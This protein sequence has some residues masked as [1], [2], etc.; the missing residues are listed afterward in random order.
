[1][2][3]IVRIVRMVP[4]ASKNVQTIGT[5][6]WKRYPDDR[7]RPGS[8]QILHDRPDRTQF[9]PSDRGRLSRPGRF[10]SSGQRFHMI[11]P[12]VWTFRKKS[13][14]RFVDNWKHRLGLESA[15][16]PLC[17]W[18]P[19]TR[20]TFLSKTFAKSLNIQKQYEKNV[21]EKSNDAY[22]LST[23]VQSTINHRFRFSRFDVFYGNINT[24]S[25]HSCWI[26]RE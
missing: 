10:R 14:P 7:K 8:L 24:G 6:I 1:M 20:Q 5:I 25:T 26:G 16:A 2:H 4:V 18:A 19:C 3:M 12:I 13:L 11:V 23:R 22:S 9:Y 15:R 21:W 17:K